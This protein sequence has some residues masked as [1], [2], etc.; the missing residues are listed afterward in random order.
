MPLYTYKCPD[1]HETD[2]LKSV[3]I[4]CIQCECGQGAQRLSV[5]R[6]SHTG[7][8]PTPLDQRTY[9]IKP[10]QE[11]SSEIAYK[12]ERAVDASQN[13]NL[14]APPLWKMAQAKAKK[15]DRLGVKD[16]ADLK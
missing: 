4:N 7:F 14:A 11:A 5:Y 10:F 1:G 9:D 3:L 6:I 8:T 15:L 16:S 12:H 13:Q 2:A